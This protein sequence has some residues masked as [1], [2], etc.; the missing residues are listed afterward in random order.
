QPALRGGAARGRPPPRRDEQLAE[1]SPR[2][3]AVRRGGGA[4]HERGGDGGQPAAHPLRRPRPESRSV[5]ALL[6]P[7]LRR[8]RVRGVHPVRDPARARVPGGPPRLAPRRALRAVLLQSL[9]PDQGRRR[10][11]QQFRRGSRGARARLLRGGGRLCRG[12]GRGSLAERGWRSTVC[13]LGAH[14]CLRRATCGASTSTPPSSPPPPPPRPPPARSGMAIGTSRATRS[15][16]SWAG[17]VASAS[18]LPRCASPQTSGSRTWTRRV[19]TCRC[20]PSTHPSSAITS[21]AR[22]GERSRARSTTRS[23]AWFGSGRNASPGSPPCPCR[24]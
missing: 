7:D 11:A 5:L 1:P 22:R 12:D 24:T 8:R 10:L 6:A 4:R 9:L 18:P 23:P 2:R 14:P 13:C 19:W 17:N 15:A 21:P 20:F 3:G 16:C